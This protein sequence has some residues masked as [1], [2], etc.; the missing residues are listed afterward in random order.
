[1]SG[2]RATIYRDIAVLAATACRKTKACCACC[3]ALHTRF[4]LRNRA[5]DLLSYSA[6]KLVCQS[7]VQIFQQAERSSPAFF[8]HKRLPKLFR[9]NT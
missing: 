6:P 3:V 9:P 5:L 2:Y 7:N 1:M 8:R 4:G